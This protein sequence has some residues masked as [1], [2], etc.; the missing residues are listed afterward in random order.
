MVVLLG[1]VY[2][3]QGCCS[4]FRNTQATAAT[5]NRMAPNV[6]SPVLRNTAIGAGQGSS[7]W[8]GGC[9]GNSV[10]YVM[11]RLMGLEELKQSG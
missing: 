1:F 2:G 7:T 9:Q 11:W 3:G 6:K 8:E 5:K 10:I 4:A